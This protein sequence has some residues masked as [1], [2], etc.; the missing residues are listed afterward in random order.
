MVKER[1]VIGLL[2]C[3]A[4]DR[5]LFVE[6]LTTRSVAAIMAHAAAVPVLLPEG[7]ETEEAKVLALRL[8]ALLVFGTDGARH[9]TFV[10]DM[11]VAAVDAARPVFGTGGGFAGINGAFGGTVNDVS[12]NIAFD[13]E[14]TETVR[15]A[16]GSVLQRFTASSSLTVAAGSAAPVVK[17]GDGL[18]SNASGS[19]GHVAAFSAGHSAA[20][21]FAVSWHPEWDAELPHDRAFWHFVGEAARA[22]YVA[23]PGSAMAP[24]L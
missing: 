22:T 3:S 17:L 6:T 11:I 12:R 4:R 19:D 9:S 8:D 20:P 18:V 10:S 23:A 24:S 16:A 15:T 1:P 13:P 21:V 2:A 14:A 5:D 7:L